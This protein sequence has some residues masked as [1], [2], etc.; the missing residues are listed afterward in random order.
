MRLEDPQPIAHG[1]TGA[2]R[3]NRRA[4]VAR[5]PYLNAAPFYVAWDQIE[6]LSEGR[7]T[8]TVLP[9]RQ[10]GLAAEA[11]EVDA[12]L[13]AVADLIRLERT[14]EPL[15]VPSAG[16]PVSFGIAN[17]DRVESVL[18]FLRT[19]RAAP[20]RDLDR[21]VF[22]PEEA[23]HLR[24]RIVGI[25]GETSTS[26]RLLRLL[27]EIRHG[28]KPAYVR[29]DLETRPP[30][31]VSGAL[32]IGDL[33]L[34]WRRSPPEGFHLAMDLAAEWYD[35][36]GLPFVF[37]R[38]GVRRDLSDT[39]KDWLGRFLESSLEKAEEGLDSLVTGLPEDLGDQSD[40]IA[41]LRNFTYRLGG[42][43]LLGAERFRMLLDEHGIACSGE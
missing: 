17:R 13:M 29:L 21:H 27:L 36:T 41:Y 8:G 4:C 22:S 24:D 7:W 19:E 23:N 14:F 6:G 35:W 32:V 34:R 37:A 42:E 28:V 2:H 10:L 31:E 20:G 26:F 11:G 16:S 39:Q 40:L 38:W 9:P 25:T 5:I 12:G 43:E 15:F 3:G 30:E 1:T 18:L 33:A